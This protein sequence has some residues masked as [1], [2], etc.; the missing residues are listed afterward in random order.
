MKLKWAQEAVTKHAREQLGSVTIPH[1]GWGD[2]Y[3]RQQAVGVGERMA[4]APFD[5]FARRRSRSLQPVAA[6]L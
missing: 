6:R 5:L 4:L 1:V 3:A 2:Y